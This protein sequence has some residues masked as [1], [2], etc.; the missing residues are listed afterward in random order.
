M[1]KE[2]LIDKFLDVIE[3]IDIIGSRFIE[4]KNPEDFVESANGVEKLD[5]IA[6]RLQVIGEIIGKINKTESQLLNQYPEVK[7]ED[8]IGMRN[9]ISH[10]YIEIDHN[11]IYKTC[12]TNLSVLKETVQKIL[13]RLN[14]SKE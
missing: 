13:I 4:I 8:I 9:V 6:M 11:I 14:E 2:L 10:A 1:H 3:C 12:K 5:S 7:W